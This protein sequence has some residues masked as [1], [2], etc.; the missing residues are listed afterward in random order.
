MSAEENRW[1]VGVVNR[2][3]MGTGEEDH[4]PAPCVLPQT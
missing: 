4:L 3:D 1:V 2:C